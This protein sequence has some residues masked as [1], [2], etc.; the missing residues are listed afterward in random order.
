MSDTLCVMVFAEKALWK[1]NYL[2][3][4]YKSTYKIDKTKCTSANL[5][6][7]STTPLYP[8]FLP[9]FTG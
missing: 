5:N 7:R 9:I 8:S 6:P 2:H 3:V 1:I 4:K